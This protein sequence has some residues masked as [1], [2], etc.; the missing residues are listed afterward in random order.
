MLVFPLYAL[1]QSMILPVLGALKFVQLARQKRS[2]GRYRFR[3][4][5]GIPADV[6]EQARLA[7]IEAAAQRVADARRA[8]AS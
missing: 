8:L 3:Y 5:R 2:I 1:A 7:R 6:L 4:R